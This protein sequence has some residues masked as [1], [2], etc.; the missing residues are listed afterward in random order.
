M[1]AI[2][3]RRALSLAVPRLLSM[4]MAHYALR[5][6]GFHENEEIS[7]PTARLIQTHLLS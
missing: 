4:R 3:G 1:Y 2:I 5:N 7:S 6:K